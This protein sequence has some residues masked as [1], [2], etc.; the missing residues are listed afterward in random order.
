MDRTAMSW[1]RIDDY[2]NVIDGHAPVNGK[3]I[4]VGLSFTKVANAAA[5][6]YSSVN[7]MSKWVQAQLNNG[8]YG[9]NLQDSIFSE[10]VHRE[11]WTPQTILRTGKGEY[12]THFKAYGLGWFLSDV[13]GYKEVTHTGGLLGIVSQVTMIPE[14]D[15]G[16]LYLP[17]SNQARPSDRLPTLFWILTSEL[18]AK[19]ELKNTMMRG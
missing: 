10:K 8:K 17:T 5:G 6:I 9:E 1:H 14:L 11:M 15:L 18:K 19:I 2:S 3:L 7:D 16:L 4:P 13:N 12:N